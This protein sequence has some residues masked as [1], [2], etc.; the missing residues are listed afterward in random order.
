MSSAAGLSD[1][2]GGSAEEDVPHSS[3]WARYFQAVITHELKSWKKRD[4]HMSLHTGFDYVPL[5]PTPSSFSSISRNHLRY[6]LSALAITFTLL[7]TSHLSPLFSRAAGGGSARGHL[8]PLFSR[9]GGSGGAGHGKSHAPF[10][11]PQGVTDVVVRPGPA[12]GLQL[13]GAIPHQALVPPNCLLSYGNLA[14]H[15]EGSAFISGAE[16]T[17][18]VVYGAVL[19]P[20]PTLKDML[21]HPTG[22]ETNVVKGQLLCWPPPDFPYKLQQADQ[23]W[24]YDPSKPSQNTVRRAVVSAVTEA[25]TVLRAFWHYQLISETIPPPA[26]WRQGQFWQWR[27]MEVRYAAVNQASTN[28]PLLLVHGFG[29]SLEHW[30]GNVEPLAADRPVYALDL[31]GFGFSSQP[32]VPKTFNQWGP[33]VWA[34]Q[35]SEFIREVIKRD[36]VL[37]GNS[38]GGYSSLLAAACPSVN[39]QVVGVVLVNS[40]GP[41]IAQKG[42]KDPWFPG[43]PLE[44]LS[45][46]EMDRLKPPPGIVESG[47]RLL[48]RAAAYGGFVMT[49]E[50]RIGQTLSLVYT[51]DKS[52][53]D[54]DLVDLIKRPALQ[55]NAYEVFFQTTLGG[56]GQNINT[57]ALLI[58]L[59]KTRLPTALLW[60]MNDPWITYKRADEYRSVAPNADFLPLSAGHCPHDEVPDA[61]NR[62]LLGWLAERGF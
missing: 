22:N 16:V 49:R 60:G 53:V 47:T 23:F 6:T 3:F 32:D 29:A 30:R 27:S 19:R 5:L 61:F 28:T 56:R 11:P 55:P 51:D 20:H 54:A 24:G 25:G 46:E 50:S 48:K 41:F 33:H 7:A 10:M 9:G 59:E 57:K 18:A 12:G 45:L 2:G 36:T 15:E 42:D 8:S 58:Q 35:V 38:L 52:R 44:V 4:P 21:A 14:Q 1:L 34:T 31:L 40:A 37:V 17:P 43:E 62:A 13:A 39:R 26:A